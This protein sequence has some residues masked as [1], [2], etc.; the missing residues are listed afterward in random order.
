[1]VY[2][3]K[4]NADVSIMLETVQM[5]KIIKFIDDVQYPNKIYEGYG[6]GVFV[7]SGIFT[8]SLFI[9]RKKKLIN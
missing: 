5:V 8:A 9:A 6:Y 7:L 3:N 1:M 4:V 2:L